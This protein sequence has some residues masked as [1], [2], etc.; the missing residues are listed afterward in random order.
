MS[1]RMMVCGALAVGILASCAPSVP[2][3]EA[4]DNQTGAGAAQSA[5]A[6]PAESAG[7]PVETLAGAWRV[8]GIDG[9]PL[10]GDIGI[11]LT[12]TA[13]EI[14]WEPRCVGLIVPYR[15]VGNRFVQ[16]EPPPAPAGSATPSPEPV[17]AVG[18]PPKV[19]E[20]GQALRG[21]E[22][23]ERTPENGIL[24]SGSGRSVL[25]FSQ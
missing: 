10:E 25:L 20:V 5:P 8:A 13:D 11:A 12:A 9:A 2:Q 3:Q 14:W 22:R 19:I 1:K 7:A 15:I 18:I 23:I 16:D 17:C 24:I 4:Q 6:V 21:G